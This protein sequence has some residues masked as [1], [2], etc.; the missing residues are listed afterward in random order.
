MKSL[1]VVVA[2]CASSS[3]PAPAPKP[4]APPPPA[5][6]EGKLVSSAELVGNTYQVRA[7]GTK[8]DAST[9][10]L[11]AFL[12]GLPLTG[13]VDL[14]VSIDVGS[15]AAD[16]AW[17]HV[18]VACNGCKL[19]DDVAKLVPGGGNARAAAFAGNG[20]DFGHLAV[21]HFAMQ[22]KLDNGVGRITA[23]DWQSPELDL[24]VSGTVELA[25]DP[26]QSVVH[27]CIRFKPTDKLRKEQPKTYAVIQLTGAPVADDGY[28]TIALEGTVGEMKRL[29]RSCP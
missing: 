29:G 16:L 15:G 1:L 24:K 10:P 27:G 18:N 21:D 14:D 3:E 5:V 19:G 20:L 6:V 28:F 17:G 7:A 8:V 12:G 26:K 2:G 13:L 25:H 9:L 11:A 4:V 22:A 23:W